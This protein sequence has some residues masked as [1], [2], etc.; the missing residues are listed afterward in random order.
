MCKENRY[1]IW[2]Y[3]IKVREMKT[4]SRLSNFINVLWDIQV[5]I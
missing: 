5:V 1:N 2:S 4:H 3:V